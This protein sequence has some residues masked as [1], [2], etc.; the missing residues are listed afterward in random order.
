MP[1]QR[2]RARRCNN[3][4]PRGRLH[5]REG[6]RLRTIGGPRSSEGSRCG[7]WRGRSRV[8]LLAA[9]PAL[10]LGE[11]P[12]RPP[13][14]GPRWRAASPAAEPRRPA[15]RLQG[16]GRRRPG[17]RAARRGGGLVLPAAGQRLGRER[18]HL[19]GGPRR[20]LRRRGGPRHAHAE[21]HRAL[22]GWA[23]KV[24]EGPKAR[25]GP[26]APVEVRYLRFAWKKSG[27]EGLMVQFHDPK[28]SWAM[29]YFAGRNVQGWEPATRVS[30]GPR[31]SGRS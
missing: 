10:G 15:L 13:P 19:P 9:V 30:P 18:H 2:H 23:F 4:L 21:V 11:K 20:V 17:G 7:I 29:R 14:L 26:K 3:P 5:S 12:L 1:E 25:P 6:P 28:K 8:R 16:A 24:V 22:P 27:G 31:P